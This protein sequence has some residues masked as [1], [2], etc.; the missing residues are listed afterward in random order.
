[1]GGILL[2]LG[3]ILGI[4]NLICF[5]LI[6][7]RMFQSG[8]STLGIICIVTLLCGIGVLLAFVMGWV[9]VAKYQAQQLMTIWSGAL[10]GSIVL[11]VLGQLLIDA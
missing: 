10:I 9:N 2:I 8:D 3:A 11:N 5:V 7:I 4:V 1:M 6:L